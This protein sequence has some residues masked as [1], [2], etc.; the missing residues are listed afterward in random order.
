ME[1]AL[2]RLLKRMP[3]PSPPP[4]VPEDWSVLESA[5]GLEYPTTYKAFVDMYGCSC[6][7]TNICPYYEPSGQ[8][9]HLAEFKKS[10]AEMMARLDVAM[11]SFVPK[12]TEVRFPIYPN[13]GGLF[14]FMIDYS[15]SIYCWQT[16]RK[17]PEAW[18]VLCCFGGSTVVVLEKMTIAKMF[19]DWLK[20]TPQMVDLWGD[21]NELP[22]EQIKVE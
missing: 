13:L 22:K 20:Q 16:D 3:P 9:A 7:F 14:P 1:L 18:P 10:M 4:R 8:I 19:L 17:N 12:R 11:Y 21:I 15:G 6:W 2:K 5:L